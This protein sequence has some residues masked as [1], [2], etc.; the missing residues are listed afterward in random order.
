MF[1]HSL[2]ILSRESCCAGDTMHIPLD[3]LLKCSLAIQWLVAA[4]V[5]WRGSKE[6][7][8]SIQKDTAH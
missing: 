6:R 5:G 3:Q 7:N 1:L 8:F 2:F 4:Y